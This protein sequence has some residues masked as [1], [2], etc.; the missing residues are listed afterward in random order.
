M[1]T[2]A[3]AMEGIFQKNIADIDNKRIQD[4][5]TKL[6]CYNLKFH[7][8]PG[9]S[10]EIADC[11][12]RMTRRIREVEHIE[13][14]EP[15][16]ADHATIK[17]VGRKSN[18]QIEDPWVERLANVAS[19]DIKYQ[20]MVQQIEMGEEFVNIQRLKDCELSSMGTYYDRLSVS[21]LKDGQS[22]ILR[23]NNE[24][25]VPEKRKE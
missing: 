18:V 4:M 11:F 7:H 10:N 14:D 1:G 24:V 19:R 15:I 8:I 9:K 25:L 3:N 23:D 20:I 21:T 5:V 6:M 2:D 12:S 16:L 13:V 22:L 17:K